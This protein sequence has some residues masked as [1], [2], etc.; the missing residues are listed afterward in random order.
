MCAYCLLCQVDGDRN[1]QTSLQPRR[2]LRHVDIR[3]HIRLPR[4]VHGGINRPDQH[5]LLNDHK[6]VDESW[7]AL[8]LASRPFRMILIHTFLACLNGLLVHPLAECLS[9]PKGHS[10]ELAELDDVNGADVVVIAAQLDILLDREV[11]CPDFLFDQVR[12]LVVEAVLAVGAD[13]NVQLK[14]ASQ[15]SCNYNELASAPW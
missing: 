15:R 14:Q 12:N 6:S 3:Q 11:V 9:L 2:P 13:T 5:R 4:L 1:G 8:D 7:V 10:F